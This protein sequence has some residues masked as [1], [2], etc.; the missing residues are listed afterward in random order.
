MNKEVNDE[1][2]KGV[3]LGNESNLTVRERYRHAGVTIYI[4]KAVEW[5]LCLQG[6]KA[7]ENKT[8]VGTGSEKRHLRING[9]KRNEML[10]IVLVF[11][12]NRCF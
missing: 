8:Y 3:C 7:N 9:V 12:L 4:I 11:S 2:K 6:E 1:I 10:Q 5:L